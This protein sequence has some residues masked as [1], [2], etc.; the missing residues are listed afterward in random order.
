[1][2]LSDLRGA[3]ECRQFGIMHYLIFPP[4]FLPTI[5]SIYRPSY[6]LPAVVHMII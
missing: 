6:S 5:A 4:I 3:L 2:P 1:M